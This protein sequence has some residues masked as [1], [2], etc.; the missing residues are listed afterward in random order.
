M[1]APKEYYPVGYE[2]NFDDNFKSKIDLPVTSF[3]CGEQRHFPGLYADEDL[4][5][6]VSIQHTL[7]VKSFFHILFIFSKHPM[8]ICMSMHAL[9]SK[10]N[11]PT[12]V[13]VIQSIIQYKSSFF[14]CDDLSAL[15]H[16]SH[17]QK[18]LRKRTK[19]ASGGH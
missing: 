19:R 8:T 13:A 16:I 6:M 12:I 1:N 17:E 11:D 2:K 7:K 15:A 10:L 4:G 14:S 5:C 3:N 9:S 18:A